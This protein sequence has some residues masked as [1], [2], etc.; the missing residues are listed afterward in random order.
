MS[1]STISRTPT[2]ARKGI[3]AMFAM[4]AVLL[5]G[6][7]LAQEA[8]AYS[9]PGSP[10][11]VCYVKFPSSA[12]KA[13]RTSDLVCRDGSANGRKYIQE[14]RVVGT[15]GIFVK[16]KLAWANSGSF[17]CG[18]YINTGYVSPYTN[19]IWTG[20]GNNYLG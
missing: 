20:A 5:G 3:A 8:G 1:S 14:I 11:P 12:S 17:R 15:H 19:C 18:R 10:M 7:G 13:P 6:V 4:F 16:T 2:T 9:R